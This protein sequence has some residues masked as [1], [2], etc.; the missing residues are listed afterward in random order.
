M[1]NLL[2]GIVTRKLKQIS[3]DEVIYHGNQYGFK[4]KK[5]E[6]DQI[7]HYLKTTEF[8]PFSYQDRREAFATLAEITSS[9]TAKKA[10]NLFIELIHSYGLTSL[11]E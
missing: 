4:V 9:E 6:A 11:L 5:H 1:S 2:K 10:E 3:P 8:D 7:S